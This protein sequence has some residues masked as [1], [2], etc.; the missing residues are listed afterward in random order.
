MSKLNIDNL[1]KGIVQLS[2]ILSGSEIVL[3]YALQTLT[4]NR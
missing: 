2:A 4:H 1:K 3:Y